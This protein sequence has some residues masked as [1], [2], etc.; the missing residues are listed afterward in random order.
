MRLGLSLNKYWLRKHLHSRLQCILGEE[1]VRWFQSAKRQILLM[2]DLL[3]SYFMVKSNGRCRRN[4]SISLRDG[5]KVIDGDKEFLLH[6]TDFYKK[7]I[8]SC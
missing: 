8:E 1:E 2:R 7:K 5:E 6:T 3:T 4:I